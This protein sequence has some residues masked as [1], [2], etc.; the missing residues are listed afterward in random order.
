M[1]NRSAESKARL[2][3]R[4]ARKNMRKALTKALETLHGKDDE[5]KVKAAFV[6][7]GFQLANDSDALIWQ[8]NNGVVLKLKSP[9]EQAQV[10][11][12][13]SLKEEN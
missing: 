8:D 3:E 7:V 13:D 1:A 9:G 12:P 5:E 4:T 2:L 11:L 10:M 6:Q